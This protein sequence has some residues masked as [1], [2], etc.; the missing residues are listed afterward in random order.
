MQLM[1]GVSLHAANPKRSSDK[2]VEFNAEEAM[3]RVPGET[4][5]KTLEDGSE[6]WKPK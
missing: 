2:I 3:K 1:T 5:F 4:T 6:E